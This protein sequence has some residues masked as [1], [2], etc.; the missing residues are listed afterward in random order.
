M[1]L[2]SVGVKMR[3]YLSL[4][5]RSYACLARSMAGRC[6]MAHSSFVGV[7]QLE[8]V[9]A[10]GVSAGAEQ[11]QVAIEQAQRKIDNLLPT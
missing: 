5:P 10:E 7:S 8:V 3:H 4:L 9:A 11:R 2:L 1:I 6:V